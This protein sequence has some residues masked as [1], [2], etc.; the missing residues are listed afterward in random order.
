MIRI[1]AI[2]FVII[3]LMVVLIVSIGNFCECTLDAGAGDTDI[4]QLTGNILI[5]SNGEKET[6]TTSRIGSNA[7]TSPLP[8]GTFC[9][10]FTI[11]NFPF[12]IQFGA[13]FA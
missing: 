8:S 10:I 12:R 2:S 4:E 6:T 11:T 5:L 3:E 1:N 7:I 13:F 9:L